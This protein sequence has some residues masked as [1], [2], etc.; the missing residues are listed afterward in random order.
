M[1]RWELLFIMIAIALLLLSESARAQ[2]PWT[3]SIFVGY[4]RS[5][6]TGSPDGSFAGR[7]NW[8]KLAGRSVGVGP[9]VGY[10]NLGNRTIAMPDPLSG[11]TSENEVGLS[12]WQFTAN[13]IG[14][15]KLDAANGFVTGGAGLYSVRTTR[16][17]M[18]NSETSIIQKFGM[19]LGG[20]ITF[21]LGSGGMALGLDGRWHGIFS[22]G[23]T[24]G[25][26]DILAVT[27]GI[28]F[29]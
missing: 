15:T 19:N 28:F 1:A 11:G 13:G 16:T 7:A 4:S 10:Y 17:T 18:F 21:N 14:R 22:F 24:G 2:G 3:G 20:G 12:T 5:L 29:N 9:E 26:L 23:D 27:A 6:E 25:T 8:F